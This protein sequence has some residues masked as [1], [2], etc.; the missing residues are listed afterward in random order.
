[1]TKL[2]NIDAC[3]ELIKAILIQAIRDASIKGL[4]TTEEMRARTGAKDFINK[5]NEMFC[6]YCELVGIDPEF[7][8]RKLKEILR[9]V[10]VK[11]K[12]F[13]VFSEERND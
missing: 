10:N 5:N 3:R 8:E 4:T 6:L 11:G 1:M 2:I 9:D 7:L 12:K 13:P